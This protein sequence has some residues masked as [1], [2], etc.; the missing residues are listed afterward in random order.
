MPDT[1]FILNC[2]LRI[3]SQPF[4]LRAVIAVQERKHLVVQYSGAVLQYKL[5]Y[6]ALQHCTALLTEP[7]LIKCLF[8]N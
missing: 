2:S 4:V 8:F 5:R 6:C 7:G 1:Y 3:V